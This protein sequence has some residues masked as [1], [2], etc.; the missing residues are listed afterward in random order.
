MLPR[1]YHA[2][3]TVGSRYPLTRVQMK[4]LI[5][6]SFGAGRR[7]ALDA[8]EEGI[9]RWRVHAVRPP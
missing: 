7:R 1:V 9:A 2:S 4:V 6:C 3:D 8:C 5:A